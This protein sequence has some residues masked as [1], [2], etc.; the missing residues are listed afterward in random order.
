[1][2]G[3]EFLLTSEAPSSVFTPED[4][5]E[6]HKAIA[7]ATDE[8]WTNEV[9]PNLD[10][11]QHQDFA[12][13]RSGAQSGRTRPD[14]GFRAGEV[15]RHGNGPGIHDGGGRRHRAR[16]ILRGLARRAHRHRHA[17]RS[18]VRHRS[19]EGEISAEARVRGTDWRPT[20]SPNRRPARTRWPPR[21]API[22]PPTARTTS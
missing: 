9:V 11:I 16:W 21:R 18:A 7:K 20:A 17:A 13:L 14:R 4:F 22:C 3:G 6:E 8:F 2:K 1:M 5:T 15:R 10:A 12:V 19:A